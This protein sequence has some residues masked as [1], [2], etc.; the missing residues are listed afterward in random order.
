MREGVGIAK[1]SVGVTGN[2]VTVNIKGGATHNIKQLLIIK[3]IQI[4]PRCSFRS[5]EYIGMVKNRPWEIM[6]LED[7][8]DISEELHAFAG[9]K[10]AWC[11][12][13]S[14]PATLILP[15]RPRSY[16]FLKWHPL[17]ITV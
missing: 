7:F 13:L 1:L 15:I 6:C 14:G 17:I 8:A 4:L 11:I 12:N 5:Y 3:L 10:M 2:Y 9:T 16:R